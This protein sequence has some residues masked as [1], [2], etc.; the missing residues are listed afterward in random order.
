M[1]YSVYAAPNWYW[2]VAGSTTKVW[3][4]PA[5]AY[6]SN[7]NSTYTAWA[8]RNNTSVI[9]SA[10]QLLTVIFTQVEP[11]VMQSGVAVTS[12][13]TP[14]INATYDV[15]SLSKLALIS[16]NIANGKGLPGGGSTFLYPDISGTTFHT[17]SATNI[18]NLAY[19]L[20]SYVYA[21][22]QMIVTRV[23]GGTASAPTIPLVIA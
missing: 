11:V 18:V 14:A 20:Q 17:F 7:T 22:E 15:T 4:S 6:V 23:G 16:A 13:S 21:W 10:G 2:V 9:N 19:A 8:A 5:L 12:T 1:A 3:S